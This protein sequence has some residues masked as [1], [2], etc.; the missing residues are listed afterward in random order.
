MRKWHQ[1]D[2]IELLGHVTSGTEVSALL[3]PRRELRST[4]VSADGINGM[5]SKPGTSTDPLQQE[6]DLSHT[7]TQ[8]SYL[9]LKMITGTI[10]SD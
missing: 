4:R 10:L 3:T 7:R 9:E 2:L 5:D 8:F 1:T 6:L